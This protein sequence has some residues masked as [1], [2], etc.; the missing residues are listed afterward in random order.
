ML[1]NNLDIDTFLRLRDDV[2]LIVGSVKIQDNGT[3]IE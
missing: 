2:E 3:P 1:I